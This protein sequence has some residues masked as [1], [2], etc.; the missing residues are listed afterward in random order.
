MRIKE[1][2]LCEF[3]KSASNHIHG[4]ASAEEEEEE[5]FVIPAPPSSSSA[6]AVAADTAAREQSRVRQINDTLKVF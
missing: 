2:T 6:A 4:M 1:P 5:F 3:N